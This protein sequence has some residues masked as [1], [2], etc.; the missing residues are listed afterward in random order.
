MSNWLIQGGALIGDFESLY[1]EDISLPTH[2][3]RDNYSDSDIK[4]IAKSIQTHGLLHPITVREK[5]VI[6][7]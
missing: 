6:L 1:L 5:M 3:L 4:E 2:T 7:R